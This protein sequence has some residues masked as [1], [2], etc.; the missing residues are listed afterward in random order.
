ME[1]MT[2]ADRIG[3]LSEGRLLHVGTPAEI[4][5]EPLNTYVA[6]RLGSPSINLL[7]DGALGIN[8]APKGTHTLGI[9]PENIIIGDTGV[10]TTI[11]GVEHLG[12]ETVIQ[13]SIDGYEVAALAP[14]GQD[15]SKGRPVSISTI[16]G[17]ILYFN[18]AGDRIT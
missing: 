10:S 16:P 6:L 12:V 14:P 13:L 11:K 2:R 8:S 17:K 9:R 18:E 4:Y 1:A 5:Q 3:V 7:P 15:F